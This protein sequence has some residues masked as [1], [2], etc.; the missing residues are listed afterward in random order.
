M[1]IISYTRETYTIYVVI[2]YIITWDT[3][4]TW[5]AVKPTTRPPLINIV[6]SYAYATTP[7]PPHTV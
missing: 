7:L 5:I 2:I 3:R 1:N 6:H 4:G